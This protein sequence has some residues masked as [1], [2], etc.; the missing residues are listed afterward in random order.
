M[1]KEAKTDHTGIPTLKCCDN[2]PDAIPL[3]E[4]QKTVSAFIHEAQESKMRIVEMLERF[5]TCV[6]QLEGFL[7]LKELSNVFKDAYQI[8]R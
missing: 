3:S 7:W 4:E 2:L 1:S 5:C 6:T 8:V